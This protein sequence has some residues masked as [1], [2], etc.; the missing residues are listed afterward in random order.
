MTSY[1]LITY[2]FST[3]STNSTNFY[4]FLWAKE[5]VSFTKLMGNLT[6][7]IFENTTQLCFYQLYERKL[8]SVI[9]SLC[10]K[11][12]VKMCSNKRFKVVYPLQYISRKSPEIGHSIFLFSLLVLK[13]VRH[14]CEVTGG[15]DYT[16]QR[17]STTVTVPVI[18]VFVKTHHHNITVKYLVFLVLNQQ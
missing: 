6:S 14:K 8:Y 17:T 13:T 4:S 12:G 10:L 7:Q 11:I 15:N 2:I 18:L 1:A 16:Q 5:R 3:H 9:V